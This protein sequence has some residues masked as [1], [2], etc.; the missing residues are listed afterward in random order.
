[1]FCQNTKKDTQIRELE[2]YLRHVRKDEGS[3]IEFKACTKKVKI[4]LEEDIT[5]V[6]A[7]LHAF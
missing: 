7:H 3:L 5:D 1:L 6:Y 4:E 2:E